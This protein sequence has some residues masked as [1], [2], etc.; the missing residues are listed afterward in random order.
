VL[1][2]FTA[3]YNVRN[4]EIVH[5]PDGWIAPRSVYDH[6]YAKEWCQKLQRSPHRGQ[7]VDQDAVYQPLLRETSAGLYKIE[8]VVRVILDH[9]SPSWHKRAAS[10]IRWTPISSS[11]QLQYHTFRDINDVMHFAR[12][13]CEIGDVTSLIAMQ[14][15]FREAWLLR[16][17]KPQPETL[18]VAKRRESR[19]KNATK[20]LPGDRF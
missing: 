14:K 11:Q 6:L 19:T 13:C 5:I 18:S 20:L 1:G 3:L 15:A 2:P 4:P 7:Y 8:N 9:D 10:S 12:V 17:I 16:Q